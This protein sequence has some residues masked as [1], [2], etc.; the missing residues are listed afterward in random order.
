MRALTAKQVKDRGLKVQTGKGK[1]S[2]V[3]QEAGV[4]KQT[5]EVVTR[6]G[7]AY[8][9][10]DRGG[11][12]FTLTPDPGFSHN[13]G[14]EMAL[15]DAGAGPPVLRDLVVTGQKSWRDFALPEKLS[16]SVTPLAWASPVG[17]SKWSRCF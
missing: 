12:A 10:V 5:G 8:R 7:T 15:F 2:A 13:P 16:L 14:R 9:G 1:L 17:L 3:E 4:D 11:K 6:P